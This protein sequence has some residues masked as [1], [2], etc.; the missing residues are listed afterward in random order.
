MFIFTEDSLLSPPHSICTSHIRQSN[1]SNTSRSSMNSRCLGLSSKG[2]SI[3]SRRLHKTESLRHQDLS[4]FSSDSPD[5]LVD[6]RIRSVPNLAVIEDRTSSGSTSS[7][8][9]EIQA[10]ITRALLANLKFGKP[11]LYGGKSEFEYTGQ[12]QS[13]RRY[14]SQSHRSHASSN[15]SLNGRRLSADSPDGGR[16]SSQLLRGRRLSDQSLGC[17]NLSD[18]SLS[19][20]RLSNHSLDD[21]HIVDILGEHNYEPQIIIPTGVPKLRKT[22]ALGKG[23][24][25]LN[26]I[27]IDN[28]ETSDSSDTGGNQLE[29]TMVGRTVGGEICCDKVSGEVTDEGGDGGCDKGSDNEVYKRGDKKDSP[30]EKK[31]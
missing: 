9:V 5:D 24:G 22:I 29:M 1:R 8:A 15:Q 7:G 17:R 28:I 4:G 30:I 14:S 18:Q 2:S 11:T 25:S 13:T 20:N 21:Y 27:G 26:D 16:C 31:V 3:R 23:K 19:N 6:S 12:S 10:L